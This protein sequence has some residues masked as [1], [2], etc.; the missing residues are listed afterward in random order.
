M[1]AHTGAVPQTGGKASHEILT[2]LASQTPL[3]QLEYDS[4]PEHDLS[5]HP[6]YAQSPSLVHE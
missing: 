1:C 6:S 4:Y 2:Q 3:L 5:L